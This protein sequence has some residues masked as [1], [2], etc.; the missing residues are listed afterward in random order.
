MQAYCRL[1][2]FHSR[3][4]IHPNSSPK[5]QCGLHEPVGESNAGYYG[6]RHGTTSEPLVYARKDESS[7]MEFTKTDGEYRPPL[8]GPIQF[9]ACTRMIRRGGAEDHQCLCVP[10]KSQS[11]CI[12]LDGHEQ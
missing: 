8:G 4:L 11:M 2:D 7:I 5:T 12:M 9:L 6:Y 1:R 10:W 3:F